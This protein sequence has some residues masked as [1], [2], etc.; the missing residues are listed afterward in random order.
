M[1]YLFYT[2]LVSCEFFVIHFYF[3]KRV[4]VVFPKNTLYF[5]IFLS[6]HELIIVVHVCE[7]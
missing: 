6:N 1:H 3:N 5:F 2:S 7:I 4:Q